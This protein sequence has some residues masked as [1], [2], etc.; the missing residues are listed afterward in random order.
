MKKKKIMKVI[1][2]VENRWIFSKGT[3]RKS[4]N[5]EGGFLSFLVLLMTT[6]LPL[7]KNVLT[8]LAKSV[9]IPLGLTAAA[10]TTDADI[11]KKICGS[12]K[13]ALTIYNEEMGDI[14]KTFKS[15][16]DSRLLIKGIGATIENEAKEQTSGFVEMLSDTLAASLLRSALTGR[17]VTIA[18]EGKIRTSQVF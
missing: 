5:Q 13:T 9:F 11:Q 7:M 4:T 8:P 3:T 12:R 2:C 17:G 14:M 15:L 10:S 6:G 16:E 18:D 1:N